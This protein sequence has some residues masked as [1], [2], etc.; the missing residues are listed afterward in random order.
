MKRL[1]LIGLFLGLA[2]LGWGADK[3]WQ[4]LTAE[5]RAAAGL[6]QLSA[7]QRTRLDQLAE[8]YVKEGARQA[9]AVAQ[10]KA[11]AEG[12]AEAIAEV[13]EQKKITIGLAPR[14]ED[15]TEVV[16]TRILGDFRGWT[17]RTTFTLVNNQVWQQEGGDNCFFPKMVDPEVE[18]RPARLGGWKLTL[19]KEGL[20][21]RVKRIR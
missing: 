17:G 4:Q 10:V 6:D 8:R 21:I 9:V 5:E 3:F 19:L 7:A 13:K 12:K 20:W 11:K 15:E 2:G 1:A 16:R 18:I 14:E